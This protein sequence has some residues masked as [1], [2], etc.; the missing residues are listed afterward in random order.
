MLQMYFL[1]KAITNQSF[2]NCR[3]L[4]LKFRIKKTT[5]SIKKPSINAPFTTPPTPPGKTQQLKVLIL[6]VK[7]IFFDYF[8]PLVGKASVKFEFIF[9][10]ALV[11]Q[12]D[13]TFI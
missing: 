9:P 1:T 5:P 7:F 10:K 3:S 8:Y 12:S 11:F 6:E 4:T 13:I 2:C